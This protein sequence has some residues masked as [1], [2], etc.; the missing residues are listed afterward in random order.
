[1]AEIEL[2][3]SMVPS[4]SMVCHRGSQHNIFSSH[5]HIGM[6]ARRHSSSTN[7]VSR[8]LA[9]AMWQN[10]CND[11]IKSTRAALDRHTSTIPLPLPD[12]TM[13]RPYSTCAS[14]FPCSCAHTTCLYPLAKGVAAYHTTSSS[15]M[16]LFP[17]AQTLMSRLS[18]KANETR[19]ICGAFPAEHPAPHV[20]KG[21]PSCCCKSSWHLSIRSLPSTTFTLTVAM[22]F[23]RHFREQQNPAWQLEYVKYDR[24]KFLLKN[25]PQKVQ[26]DSRCFH[27]EGMN[28]LMMAR[29]SHTKI[30][31]MNRD[32]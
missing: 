13:F 6:S 24:Y 25:I 15:G 26:D 22:R 27:T 3:A 28:T 32:H 29:P 10:V 8:S 14:L 30:L 12:P 20:C 21:A 19:A 31:T 16:T 2:K 4:R 9:I 5:L 11:R 18:G 7:F 1:M 17:L 23:G